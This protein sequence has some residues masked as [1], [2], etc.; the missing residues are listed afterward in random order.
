MFADGDGHYAMV[1]WV[2]DITSMTEWID[3]RTALHLFGYARFARA[4]LQ[5]C[6]SEAEHLTPKFCDTIQDA[7]KVDR[8]QFIPICSTSAQKASDTFYALALVSEYNLSDTTT[9]G[10]LQR[11]TDEK[12][13]KAKQTGAST[14]TSELLVVYCVD[15]CVVCAHEMAMDE[16]DLS[17]AS[18]NRMVVLTDKP[19]PKFEGQGKH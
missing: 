17:T 18:Y 8:E 9:S 14:K 15:A 3:I 5:L 4:C 1:C 11:R 7:I 13:R 19:P 12:K 2:P 16:T 10:T 6:L